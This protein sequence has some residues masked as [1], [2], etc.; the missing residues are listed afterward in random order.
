[1]IKGKSFQETNSEIIHFYKKRNYE[2]AVKNQTQSFQA[3]R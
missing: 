2:K 3:A 1:M